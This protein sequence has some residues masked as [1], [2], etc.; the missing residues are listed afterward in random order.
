MK[1]PSRISLA[2]TVPAVA[3]IG[4]LALPVA[5]AHA[6]DYVACEPD[7]LTGF[8]L[9]RAA[10]G[11]CVTGLDAGMTMIL[12]TDEGLL[13][14]RPDSVP[15]DPNVT[16]TQ[17]GFLLSF[18]D[19]PTNLVFCPSIL[20]DPMTG[21]PTPRCIAEPSTFSPGPAALIGPGRAAGNVYVDAGLE[22]GCPSSIQ[23]S[24]TVESPAGDLFDLA[25]SLSRAWSVSSTRSRNR[26]FAARA[27]RKLNSAVRALPGCSAPVGLGANRVTKS[28][29]MADTV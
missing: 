6:A 28:E 20:L 4:L 10:A 8:P 25:G 1:R 11:L 3:L 27:N 12:R 14:F 29:F 13:V 7:P 9:P 26:P 17:D 19:R 2:S 5:P 21:A 24:A 15:S 16:A 23:V 18:L 22:T